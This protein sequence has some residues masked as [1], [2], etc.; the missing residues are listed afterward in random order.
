MS[1]LLKEVEFYQLKDLSV[2]IHE[3]LDSSFT[4]SNIL[5]QQQKEWSSQLEKWI[6]TK[7][8]WILAFKSTSATDPNLAASCWHTCAGKGEVLLVIKTSSGSVIGGYT[9][10]GLTAQ[11]Q[12]LF[13][14]STYVQDAAAFL[15]RLSGNPHSYPCQRAANA[16]Q[17]SDGAGICFGQSDLL[18]RGRVV[19]SQQSGVYVFN[20]SPLLVNGSQQE[21]ILELEAF[22]VASK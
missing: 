17:H 3:L 9:R 14:H 16:L 1:L 10:V 2:A 22:C 6:G 8:K 13:G 4:G 15:F 12:Q 11:Y 20:N 19:Y 18:I 7:K 21:E 5:S